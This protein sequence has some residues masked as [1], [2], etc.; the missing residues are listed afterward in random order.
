MTNGGRENYFIGRIEVQTKSSNTHFA[1]HITKKKR[2]KWN[3]IIIIF[4]FFVRTLQLLELYLVHHLLE[5]CANAVELHV[6]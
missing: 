1:Q 3:A 6:R 2:Y 4:Q 5:V